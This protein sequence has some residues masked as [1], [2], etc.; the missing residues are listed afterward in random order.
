MGLNWFFRRNRCYCC[1]RCRNA[2]AVSTSS[3]Y[4]VYSLQHFADVPMRIYYG[5]G[6]TER[7]VMEGMDDSLQTIAD[8]AEML[9]SNY[10][11]S[12]SCRSCCSC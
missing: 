8:A 11:G 7:N 2:Q 10:R 1:C 3:V 12:G 4:T 9:Q 5:P 6:Y